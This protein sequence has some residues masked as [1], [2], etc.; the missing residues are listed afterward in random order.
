MDKKNILIACGG[1]VAG[2][3]I[4]ALLVRSGACPMMNKLS[5]HG[6]KNCTMMGQGHGNM[7]D[8][9][10]DMVEGL[11][12]KRGDAFDKA[13]IDEMVIHHEG[14]VAMAEEVLEHSSRP[15][16][17]KLANEIISAQ[18]KE[19]EQMKAWKTQWFK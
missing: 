12:G 10:S 2:I 14:A 13:F 15:E 8:M 11:E 3:I 16:L 4:G 6:G 17:L 1:I 7:S 5:G 18:T 9:M 19:I